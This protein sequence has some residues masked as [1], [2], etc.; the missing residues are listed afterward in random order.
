MQ[1]DSLTFDVM[2]LAVAKERV[3]AQEEPEIQIVLPSKC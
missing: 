1:E 2:G 3:K